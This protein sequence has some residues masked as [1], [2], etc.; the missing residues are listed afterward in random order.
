MSWEY[1]KK[2]SENIVWIFSH[3]EEEGAGDLLE[4]DL[5]KDGEVRSWIEINLNQNWLWN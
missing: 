1:T 3:Y 2:T 5:D 4:I